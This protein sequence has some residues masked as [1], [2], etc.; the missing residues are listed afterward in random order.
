ICVLLGLYT[1]SFF[2]DKYPI[3]QLSE[4]DL[5]NFESFCESKY[6]CPEVQNLGFFKVCLQNGVKRGT[7]LQ[8]LLANFR[9]SVGAKVSQMVVMSS[10]VEG[11]GLYSHLQMMPE[12]EVAE[13]YLESTPIDLAAVPART[14]YNIDAKTARNQAPKWKAAAKK[15]QEYKKKSTCAKKYEHLKFKMQGEVIKDSPEP[16]SSRSCTCAECSFRELDPEDLDVS[17]AS[18]ILYSAGI[19]EDQEKHVEFTENFSLM[20]LCYQNMLSILPEVY[21]GVSSPNLYVLQCLT[22]WGAQVLVGERVFC[23]GLICRI[24][25]P[26]RSVAKLTAA[27]VLRGYI[28][29]RRCSNILGHKSYLPSV[30]WLERED[31]PFSVVIQRVGE[32]VVL[33]PNSP[34][35][36]SNLSFNWAEACNFGTSSWIP[37]GITYPACTCLPD[38]IHEMNLTPVV[39]SFASKL[40]TSYLRNGDILSLVPDFHFQHSIVFPRRIEVAAPSSNPKRL[41]CPLCQWTWGKDIRR[42]NVLSHLKKH[43]ED[44]LSDFRTETFLKQNFPKRK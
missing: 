7:S 13:S 24:V 12:N 27:L 32:G 20:T 29:N 4:Q 10:P 8:E 22:L 42:R 31:I 23:S 14:K 3:Y 19:D 11:N 17:P 38:N 30:Q 15:L 1:M 25:I 33:L 35:M 34:H 16:T 9:G 28:D 5:Q 21:N 44:L 43:H 40:L 6:T 26:P 2:S 36:G 41:K 37:Y 18:L 39:T